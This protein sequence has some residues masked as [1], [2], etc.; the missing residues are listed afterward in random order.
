[1]DEMLAGDN[2]IRRDD[3]Q[4]GKYDRMLYLIK[5][6]ESLGVTTAQLHSLDASEQV[7]SQLTDEQR[8]AIKKV[9]DTATPTTILHIG[10]TGSPRGAYHRGTG[11]LF[12]E[13]AL[14]SI[15]ELR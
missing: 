9:H 10:G 13:G 6:R 8:E 1:T 15:E 12:I 4:Y 5:N 2:D 7:M 14:D 3:G 11:I